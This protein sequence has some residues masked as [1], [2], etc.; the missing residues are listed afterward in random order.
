MRCLEPGTVKEIRISP[1]DG[2]NWEEHGHELA[3][4]VGGKPK[5]NRSKK[6]LEGE[7]V[8]GWTSKARDC[9][10]PDRRD[11]DEKLDESNARI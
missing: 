5:P 10:R 1:F 3:H 11:L 9:Y 8:D 2:M 7:G 6:N 4:F